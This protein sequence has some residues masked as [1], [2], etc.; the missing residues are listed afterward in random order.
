MSHSAI[1]D[2]PLSLF[3]SSTPLTCTQRARQQGDAKAAEKYLL[4]AKGVQKEKLQKVAESNAKLAYEHGRYE[5]GA[6]CI[7]TCLHS[8]G[9]DHVM[10]I[11]RWR[12]T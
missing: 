5:R 11:P 8:T 12:Q 10:H 9:P 6:G 2:D 1:T 3:L 7:H 4:W